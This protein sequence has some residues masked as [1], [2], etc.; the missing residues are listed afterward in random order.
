MIKWSY[1]VFFVLGI[2]S[3]Q[4]VNPFG[5]VYLGE[6]VCG[7]AILLNLNSITIPSVYKKMLLLLLIWFLAQFISDV[8]NQTDFL[9]AVKGS[10]VP[11]LIAIIMLGLTLIFRNQYRK[12]PV[13]LLGVYIG[14]LL[15]KI[16][17][18]DEYF[19][20]NPWKWGFGGCVIYCFYTLIE[21]KTKMIRAE[22]LIACSLFIV[23]I[24]L[25]NSSRSMAVILLLATIIVSLSQK[26]IAM[27]FYHYLQKS[28]LGNVY[29]LILLLFL[30]FIIDRVFVSIFTFQPLLDLLPPKDA[31]KY[32]I[33]ANNA[34]GMLLGGR[35]ELLISLK[36]FYDSPLIGFGSMAES[37]FYVFEYI[38]MVDEAG[39]LLNSI[40]VA[41]NKLTSFRIP[42]HSFLMGALVW[43]GIFAGMFWIYTLN[44]L[45]KGF[46]NSKIITSPL[47]VYI[48]LS[49][50][51]SIW[52]SPFGADARWVGTLS[53]WLYLFLSKVYIKK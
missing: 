47:L 8:V 11:V 52:F 41:E 1:I 2:I 6:I 4:K 30:I 24:C 28:F 16:Y 27:P 39:G 3:S 25:V 49:L 29:F 50:I 48:S 40:D 31:F 34:W 45:I 44:I 23:L 9:K 10:L 38:K 32:K 46:L 13:Y 19:L 33:Q 21:F 15:Q 12:L 22:L 42:T 43:G 14:I 18:G 5:E 20:S 17:T 53:L 37:K 51:W 7:I 36:A 26:I 35:T